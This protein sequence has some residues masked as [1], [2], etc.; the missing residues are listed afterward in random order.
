MPQTVLTVIQ[1]YGAIA[2]T[3]AALIV[4]MDL[5][6]KW[7]GAAM[8]IFVTSSLSLIAWGFL[9]PKSEGIGMQNVALLFINAFGVWK[10]LI[11]PPR[12]SAKAGGGR[13]AHAD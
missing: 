5:G 4:S 7:T 9:Q 13:R 6:R 3:L 10:Y 8:V 12:K 2:A 11:A 1:Y